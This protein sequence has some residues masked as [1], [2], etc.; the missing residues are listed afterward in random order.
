MSKEFNSQFIKRMK[1]ILVGMIVSL[2]FI[3]PAFADTDAVIVQGNGNPGTVSQPWGL[4]SDQS[5][6][7]TA[8]QQVSD[9]S[10]FTVTCP[11]WEFGG[12]I[13]VAAT[14]WYAT[15]MSATAQ[16]LKSLGV[17]SQFPQFT[18]WAK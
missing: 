9:A 5:V 2:A 3:T 15:A 6:H 16:Q 4:T 17:L 10:G 18:Y 8:G 11:T 13:N 7:V 1:K 12:C 14:P